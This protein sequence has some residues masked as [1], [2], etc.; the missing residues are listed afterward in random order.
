MYRVAVE[1]ILGLEWRDGNRMILKPC[2]PDGWRE[3]TIRWRPPGGATRYTIT[4]SNPRG[5][6]LGVAAADVDGTMIP[7]VAG[8]AH[9]ELAADGLEHHVHLETGAT[10]PAPV[11][12][13]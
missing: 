9:L 6:G 12:T 10:E 7:I 4:L 11:A 2:L 1:S 13:A 5:A 8:A 3:A